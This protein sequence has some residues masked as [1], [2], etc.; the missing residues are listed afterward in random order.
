MTIETACVLCGDPIELWTRGFQALYTLLDDW[1]TARIKDTRTGP[2]R[3]NGWFMVDQ[4]PLDSSSDADILALHPNPGAARYSIDL[5]KTRFHGVG[6][7]DYSPPSATWGFPFHP[8]CWEMLSAACA[9]SGTRLDLKVIFDLWRSQPYKRDLLDWGH[10]YGGNWED[11]EGGHTVS[12]PSTDGILDIYTDSPFHIP[13]LRQLFTSEIV[14]EPSRNRKVLTKVSLVC[15]HEGDPFIRLPVEILHM[16]LIPTDSRDVLNLRLASPVYATLVLP[17]SFWRSRFWQ[18]REFEHI[19]EVN[20]LQISNGGW[21]QLYERIKDLS[22]LPSLTNRKIVWGLAC[23]LRELIDR[24]LSVGPCYGTP[25]CTMFEPDGARHNFGWR[26]ASPY[27]SPP[28]EYFYRRSRSLYERVTTLPDIIKRIFI[29]TVGINSKIYISGLRFAGDNDTGYLLGF[30]SLD[31]EIE[32]TW[33]TDQNLE[34]LCG[35][36]VAFD[37]KGIRGLRILSQTGEPSNWVGEWRDTSQQVLTLTSPAQTRTW[38]LKGGF[39]ALKLVSIAIFYIEDWPRSPCPEFPDQSSRLRE[40]SLWYGEIPPGELSLSGRHQLPLSLQENKI[41]YSLA[42][43]GGVDG[44]QLPCLSGFSV[45]YT[46]YW[47]TLPS[48]GTGIEAIEFSFSRPV[49]GK[50]SIILGR[51][52]DTDEDVGVCHVTL[53]SDEGERISRLS[54][55]YESM[56]DTLVDIKV[57]T[58]HGRSYPFPPRMMQNWGDEYTHEDLKPESGIIVGIFSSITS[59]LGFATIGIASIPSLSDTTI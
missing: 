44:S 33:E 18:G 5:M 31:K 36:H 8:D 26:V 52:P 23:R 45:Y 19:F 55:T 12:E 14:C 40:G 9:V 4:I 11:L 24:R 42:L 57:H 59:E 22:A 28:T 43:F 41:P 20:T 27:L 37:F 38:N 39:D 13:T 49:N 3:A 51:V 10:D 50:S 21:R 30:C 29:S 54:T 47:D 16:I 7:H 56:T 15:R 48:D 32:V 25:Q 46:T 17:D 2:R 58:N 34:A 35:F 1:G 53:R 6:R